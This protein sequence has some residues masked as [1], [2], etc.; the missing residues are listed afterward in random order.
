MTKSS[1][2]FKY[3]SI[4][5]PYDV[6]QTDPD[7]AP[8]AILFLGAGQVG[9][10]AQWV[11]EHCPP[12]TLIVQGMP[13]WLVSDVDIVNFA[14]TYIE[15]IVGKLVPVHN[16]SKV[17]ILA[18]S[19]AAAAVTYVF[20]NSHYKTLLNGFVLIQPL[21]LNPTAYTKTSKP[22]TIFAK[23]TAQ[24]LKSQLPQFMFE[25]RL[26]HNARQL[27]RVVNFRNPI[28]RAHYESG[29]KS[30]LAPDL[31]TIHRDGHRVAIVCGSKD[32]LFPPSEIADTLQTYRLN[33]PLFQLPTV[34]HSPLAT[35]YGIWLLE[36]AF[37]SLK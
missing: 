16:L 32:A 27:S 29:L 6:W 7:T 10:L 30:N 31:L 21:G 15:K 13:H 22:L 14:Y 4:R 12:G 18:E 34:P 28:L 2:S 25:S 11:A 19:Q 26:R 24:N 9:L 17:N 35:R 5:I 8:K 36:S 3:G 20:A 33:V 23:R 37:E 1:Y